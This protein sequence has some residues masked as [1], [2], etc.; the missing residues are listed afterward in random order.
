MKFLKT[1]N[2]YFLGDKLS[3]SSSSA[4]VE[5]LWSFNA[6]GTKNRRVNCITFC[7]NSPVSSLYLFFE[8]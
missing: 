3:M 8:M 4:S 6:E 1:I 5:K 2:F 7:K